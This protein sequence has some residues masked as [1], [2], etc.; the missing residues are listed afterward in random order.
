MSNLFKSLIRP[1]HQS[2]FAVALCIGILIGTILAL[3]FRINFFSSPLWL[4]VAGLSLVIAYLKPRAA[5][6]GIAIFAGLLLSFYRATQ[7]LQGEDYIRQFYDQTVIITGTVD[8]DPNNDESGTKFKLKNLQFGEGEKI[9]QTVGNIYVTLKSTPEIARSDRIT[10]ESKLLD[11]FGTY[12]GYLYKPSV[13]NL[14]HPSPGDPILNTRNWFADKIKSVIS[15][16][17]SDLGLSYLLSMKT[18]LSD[19][20]S[21]NL[22]TVGL[23]HIVVASGAHLSIL[24]EIARRIFGKFSRFSGLLFSVIFILFFMALVGFTP[25][26]MRAGIMSIL[27]IIAWYVG[28]KF[29]AWRLILIVAAATL[30]ISPSYIIN[31]G[32]LLSFASFTGIM[33]LGP[34]LSQFFYG[35]RQPKFIASTIL[36]TI[37]ATLMTLPIILYYFGTVSLI[38]VIANLLILPT[39]PFAMGLTFLT[40]VVADIPFINTVVGFLTTKLLDFHIATVSFFAEARSFLIEIDP[41]QSWVFLIYS[42]VIILLGSGLIRQKMLKSKQVKNQIIRE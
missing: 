40:G 19:D 9:H 22:R 10:L 18:G 31:L 39:L 2:Y 25:S 28:R 29:A 21:D 24:V 23:V 41:Y 38:S 34:R 15:E 12:A 17:V 6:F 1:I 33:V 27:T 7:E 3:V 36:T 5:L 20:L 4:I 32:W 37:S 8:G 14:A 30:L 26:I 16:P 13:K 42:L 35:Q 11:G